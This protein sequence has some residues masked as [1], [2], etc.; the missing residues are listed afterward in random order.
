MMDARVPQSQSQGFK[1]EMGWL[2]V[3]ESCVTGPR[4]TDKG[5]VQNEPRLWRDR[6]FTREAAQSRNKREPT[7]FLLLSQ[8]FTTVSSGSCQFCTTAKPSQNPVIKDGGMSRRK[9]EKTH[10]TK[11]YMPTNNS[12]K[13][14]KGKK[15]EG[16]RQQWEEKIIFKQKC[17]MTSN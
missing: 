9:T 12:K 6:A 13:K 4:T 1:I 8:F 10:N 2:T 17:E 3:C 7:L 16:D 5:A 11:R 14:K 15:P